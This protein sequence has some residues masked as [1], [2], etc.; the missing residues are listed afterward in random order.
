MTPAI[1][2]LSVILNQRR[3]LLA[4]FAS[5]LP[6]RKFTGDQIA[7]GIADVGPRGVGFIQVRRRIAVR[8]A[9]PTYLLE[10]LD[11]MLLG[12]TTSRLCPA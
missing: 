1:R 4:H 3:T 7:D 9:F 8:I 2:A 12:S 11:E 6:H 5:H 10:V